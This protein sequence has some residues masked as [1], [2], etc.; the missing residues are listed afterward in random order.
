MNTKILSWDHHP[1]IYLEYKAETNRQQIQSQPHKDYDFSCVR[2]CTEQFKDIMSFNPQSHN[3]QKSQ[4]LTSF[5]N[6][7]QRA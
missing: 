5:A 4:V 3:M 2:V 1:L 6:E 7:A